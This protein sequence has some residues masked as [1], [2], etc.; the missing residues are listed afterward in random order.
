MLMKERYIRRM[1]IRRIKDVIEFLTEKHEEGSDERHD[2]VRAKMAIESLERHI[3]DPG[4]ML[5]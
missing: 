2:L 3:E 5:K 1:D 4:I